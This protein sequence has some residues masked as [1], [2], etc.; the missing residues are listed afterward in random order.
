M[1][2]VLT[3]SSHRTTAVF[4]SDPFLVSVRTVTYYIAVLPG[5]L[6]FGYISTKMRSVREVLI[7]AFLINLGGLIGFATIQPSQNALPIAMAAVQG[8][9]FGGLLSQII[10]AAQVSVPHNY[11]ATASAVTIIC[12]AL[13]STVA[14]S[15]YSTAVN[16]RLESYIPTYVAEAAVS[17]GLRADLVPPFITA[18]TSGNINAIPPQATPQ[19]IAGG[20]TALKQ[21]YADGL[22]VVPII[23]AP[24]GLT[25]IL[26]CCFMGSLKES[27][28]YHVDAPVEELHAK[29]VHDNFPSEV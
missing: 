3:R 14:T 15:I 27:F 28:T 4:E 1:G 26:L 6:V 13:A 9:G 10:A 22:R 21:A 16:S 19:I 7:V 20:L 23:A 25:A 11:I 18:L 29:R 5:T 17:A 8:F 12:R 24:L 2:G